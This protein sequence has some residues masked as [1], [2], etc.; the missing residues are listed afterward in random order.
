MKIEFLLVFLLFAASAFAQQHKTYPAYRTGRQAKNEIIIL[1]D[2]Y[3]WKELFRGADSALLFGKKYNT[4]DSAWRMK[5]YWAAD[6]KTRR[7]KL[8]PFVWN[9][10]AK[11][12]QIYGNRDLGNLVN[13]KNKY[14]FSEP[15]RSETFC[16]YYD[17][18]INSNDKIDNP[19]ENVLEF[20]N[21]QKGYE[22]KVVTF[23]SWDVVAWILNRDRN[24]MLVN[25]YGEDVKGPNLTPLQKN[26]NAMQHY[27]H[28]I[29]G[30]GE[31]PD[32]NTFEMAKAYIGTNHPR[33]LYIDFG[34]N[35][36][37]AHEGKYDMYLDAAN[38][39]DAMIADLWNYLQSD[40][41]YNNQTSILIFPDHGRG[42]D[43][44]WTSHGS[45]I[46]HANE[47]YLMVMGP[48]TPALGEVKTKGQLFQ[49]QFAQTIANLLGFHFT[50]NHPVASPVKSVIK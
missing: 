32:A 13:V 1:M 5:K 28:D 15:G 23:A 30:Q 6:E 50:A 42:Y 3:R 17:T 48:D 33:V 46:P 2:G 49:D 18:L 12:G 14:W 31:R 25:I 26:A 20:I 21:K 45:K 29:F 44:E 38:K 41:F 36:E 7:E 16:G 10:I 24:K 4:Q 35:D 9:H 22:G 39:I 47:T 40:T 8:M 19:N 43:D 34:D 37:C 11:K 27:V